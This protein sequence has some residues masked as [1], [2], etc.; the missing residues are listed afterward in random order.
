MV[1]CQCLPMPYQRETAAVFLHLFGVHVSKSFPQ[2]LTPSGSV[3]R[4]LQLQWPEQS[5]PGDQRCGRDRALVAESPSV[6]E[7]WLQWGECHAGPWPGELLLPQVYSSMNLFLLLK[8][9]QQCGDCNGVFY[10]REELRTLLRMWKRKA[11][12][13]VKPVHLIIWGETLF[14]SVGH[15]NY[16]F[17][18]IMFTVWA[19]APQ[20]AVIMWAMCSYMAA[21]EQIRAP[22]WPSKYG[23][24]MTRV[25]GGSLARGPWNCTSRSITQGED[26]EEFCRWI[27]D[28]RDVESD[29]RAAGGPV[30]VA[31]LRLIVP[32]PKRALCR[33]CCIS[34]R[35]PVVSDN[36]CWLF[37]SLFLAELS[38][39]KIRHG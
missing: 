20:P 15:V 39:A 29:C 37:R 23:P 16:I 5:P 35:L 21:K 3:L 27:R 28:Q 1:I 18:L 36:V 14:D 19:L 11:C 10:L 33:T 38:W 32:K 4:L 31:G 12:S 8:N 22:V 26:G 2:L 34:L 13:S 17:L 6:Q 30:R 25:S 9:R 24:I 7:S